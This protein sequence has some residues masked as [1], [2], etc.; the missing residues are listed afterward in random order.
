MHSQLWIRLYRTTPIPGW[1]E[2]VFSCHC[3]IGPAS[4]A[5]RAKWAWGCQEPASRLGGAR[6]HA[7][8]FVT[9]ATMISE[10]MTALAYL[11]VAGLINSAYTLPLKLKLRWKW[12]NM[13]F[14]FTIIG[15]C[16]L[17]CALGMLTIPDF[18]LI[19]DQIELRSV[20]VV[21]FSGAIWGVGMLLSGV[22]VGL[23]GVAAMFATVMGTSASVGAMLPLFVKGWGGVSLRAG[24][25]LS[26]GI[27]LTILGVALCG[28]AGKQR[29]KDEAVEVG[30]R[31]SRFLRGFLFAVLAGI[32]G[33]MLNFGLAAGTPLIDAARQHGSSARMATNAAWVP[34]LL[35]GAIPGILYCVYLLKK[36]GTAGNF[37]CWSTFPYLFFPLLMGVLW[38]GS[39]VLYGWATLR[40]GNLGEIVGWP[41]FMVTI[42]LGSAL[43][44]VV[45]GEWKKA[46]GRARVLMASAVCVLVVA[47]IVLTGARV[48]V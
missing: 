35:A 29:E 22:A 1:N 24:L 45:T 5:T 48:G 15:I 36:N 16:I 30:H 12:E 3:F 7:T 43:W 11:V 4:A 28:C 10:M 31:A 23:I 18:W 8:L 27:G 42:V 32:S 14:A 13:W 37:L 33:S 9:G 46:S 17:P 21:A 40:I 39:V 44:G 6:S 26:L 20:L 34:V 25:M 2:G 41:L 47:I 38:F 19:Y